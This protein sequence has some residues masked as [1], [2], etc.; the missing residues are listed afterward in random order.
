MTKK[1]VREERVYL[2]YTSILLF[3]T[4]GSQD[5]NSSRAGTWRQKLM[6]RPWRG[7]AYWLVQ[8]AFLQTPPISPGVVLPTMG[9]VLSHQSLRKCLTVG[10]YGGI[11]SKLPPFR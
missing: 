9:W 7:A 8:L 1:Q 11:F 4:E 2:A 5:R 10:S 3:I 6:H